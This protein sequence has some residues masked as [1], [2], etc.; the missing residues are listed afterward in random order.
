MA[1][2]AVTPPLLGA[3]PALATALIVNLAIA[4]YAT[5]SHRG[6][7]AEGQRAGVLPAVAAALVLAGACLWWFEGMTRGTAP[8]LGV[9]LGCAWALLS[10]WRGAA[11][12]PAGLVILAG[13]ALGFSEPVA[14]ANAAIG[15]LAGAA[16]T[17]TLAAVSGAAADDT[18]LALAV[19]AQVAGAAAWGDQLWAESHVGWPLALLLGTFMAAGLLIARIAVAPEKPGLAAFTAAAVAG[20]PAAAVLIGVYAAPLPLVWAVLAGAAGGAVLPWLMADRSDLRPLG[21]LA[22]LAAGGL[23]LV[24]DNR[25]LG[26]VAIGLGGVGLA[27]G[28]A[29]RVAVR[30]WVGLLVGLFATRVWIQLFLDR[31]ALT[32]YGVDL[33]H[34]YAFAALIAGA[35]APAA[36]IAARRAVGSHTALGVAAGLLVVLAPVALGYFIHVG[37][38]GAWLAGVAL[39]V[40]AV[41]AGSMVGEE[42]AEPPLADMTALL[43]VNVG[44]TLLAAPW[45]V[46]VMNATREARVGAFVGVAVALAALTCAWWAVRGR[47]PVAPSPTPA[48]G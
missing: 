41:A 5:W 31:T 30:P 44:V 1:M 28:L 35:L 16:A 36:A 6:S 32:G 20:L 39:G 7:A 18:P 19:L 40:F 26:I 47:M 37:P 11:A 46:T 14:L 15:M 10:A 38:L 34:P 3:T 27:A 12:L 25:L 2:L 29:G 42:A 8:A 22:F 48:E 33:T 21:R 17:R 4:A 24:L 13:F 43:L 9:V 45:L 23:L